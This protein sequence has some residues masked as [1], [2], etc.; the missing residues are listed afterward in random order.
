MQDDWRAKSNLTINLGLR[1]EHETP[2][3]ERFNRGVNGFDPTAV[4]DVT[5]ASAAAYNLNPISQVPAGQFQP[6]GGLTFASPSN[7][8]LYQTES[9]MFS[10]R[11]GFAWVPSKLG[12]RTVIRGGIATFAAPIIIS[13]NGE[14]NSS[15]TVALNEEGFSQTTQLVTDSTYHTPGPG[16]SNPF[17]AGIFPPAGSSGGINTYLGQAITFFNPQVR[18]PYDVRWNLG[19][20]RQLPAS[21][22][23]EVVYIGNHALH[24]PINT[25]LDYIPPQYLTTALL[26]DSA[27]NSL[28]TGTVTNPFKGLLPNGGALNQPRAPLPDLLVRFPQYGVNGITEQSAGAASTYSQSLNVRL[29]KRFTNGLT[30]MNNFSWSKEIERLTYLNPF[31]TTPEKVV[32]SD[33]RPLSEIMAATYNLPIGRGQR[34]NLRSRAANTLLGG[35]LVSGIM[36][37]RSGPV[38]GTWG[39]V[40]YLGGPLDFNP[41]QPNGLAFDTSRFA[42]ASNQQP[43]FNI[44]TFPTQFG[45]LL[46]AT[47]ENLDFSLSKNFAFAER[48]YIQLRGDAFNITNH[49]TFGAPN[50]TPTNAAF[51]TITTQANS[52]RILQL[53]AR[54]IF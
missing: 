31:D 24:L 4:N 16:L 26:R 30:L 8:G 40:A 9:Y 41:N 34:L 23:L 36:T 46:R 19:V 1:F 52:P 25:N 50:I 18:N 12:G 49:V 10:P 13:G 28:M 15:T 7:P 14:Q 51:G 5:A 37:F 32:S 54:L 29:Q 39:N 45:N 6:L 33:S 21:M 3:Y 20:Q 17:S 2:T 43:V 38:L 35:W 53:G 48:R 44:R 22:V 47:S 27:L 42:T 11:F